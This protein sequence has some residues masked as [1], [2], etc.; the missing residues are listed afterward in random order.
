MS[1]R[2]PPAPTNTT[3]WRTTATGISEAGL[4][5]RPGVQAA[6]ALVVVASARIGIEPAVSD[7]ARVP[8]G[9]V[10]LQFVLQEFVGQDQR[11]YGRAQISAARCDGLISS[12][13]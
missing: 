2:C 3:I 1:R 7:A 8:L 10:R 11:T 12:R 5:S 13:V 4:I 9:Y 6:R